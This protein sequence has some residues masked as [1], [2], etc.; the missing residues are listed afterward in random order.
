IALGPILA[1]IGLMQTGWRIGKKFKDESTKPANVGA[2]E[3]AIFALLGLL[4]AFTFSNGISRF[5]DRRKLIVEEA[6]DIGTAFCASICC[7]RKRSLRCA[8]SSVVI[9]IRVW[10]R[11]DTYPISKLQRPN[12]TAAISYSS[13]SGPTLSIIVKASRRLA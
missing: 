11:T 13:K 7:R 3:G 6:N 2:I 8:I 4:I 12:L 10:Q 9:L 5:E 1:M